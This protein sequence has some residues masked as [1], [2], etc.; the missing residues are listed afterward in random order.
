MVL[1]QRNTSI[2]TLNWAII[3]IQ[4]SLSL[5]FPIDRIKVST[6]KNKTGFIQRVAAKHTAHRI[7]EQALDIPLQIRLTDGH[8]FILHFRGQLVL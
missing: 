5:V 7:A 6:C 1:C 8:I 4:C 2:P 3:F